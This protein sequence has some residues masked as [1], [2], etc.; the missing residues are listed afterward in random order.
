M[1]K[2]TTGLFDMFY[3]AN[4]DTDGKLRDKPIIT[5]DDAEEISNVAANTGTNTDTN[6]SSDS[7]DVDEPNQ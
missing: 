4:V 5:S 2:G 1:D 6:N 3:R 7:G